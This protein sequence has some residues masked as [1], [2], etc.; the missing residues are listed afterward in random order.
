M[1][2][3]RMIAFCAAVA[4]FTGAY[5]VELSAKP[6]TDFGL[7]SW[8]ENIFGRSERKIIKKYIKEANINEIYQQFNENLLESGK[9]EN[10]VK[11]MSRNNVDVY[12]LMG[13]AEWAYEPDGESLIN[14]IRLISN[15]NKRQNKDG[16]IKG[17]MVDVEPHLLEEWVYGEEGLDILF[18]SYL[19]CM[20]NAYEY[21]V[22]HNLE[23]WACIPNS[24][25][26][27][28]YYALKD[29]VYS[30]CD[31]IAVMNY[32]RRDEYGQMEGEVELAQMC[33]KKVMCIYELQQVGKHS[34]E[35][36]N[37]YANEG[38]Y[39]LWESARNLENEFNYEGLSFAYHYYE[40]L[41]DL[42]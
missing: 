34:L 39:A 4:V 26:D 10:F 42:L 23:F 41:K 15:Y 9:A 32:N 33:G 5:F 24:Y 8:G 11:Y 3:K 17:V 40:P 12:A 37:T 38:I 16:K 1:R 20:Q 29:L 21:A 36:I 7:F 2:L 18:E 6:E 14:E 30:A 25:D 27:I 13:E 19:S 35:G 31:G 28:D 22:D